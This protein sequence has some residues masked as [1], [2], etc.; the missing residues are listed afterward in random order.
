MA[1]APAY[2]SPM[3]MRPLIE[4]EGY[5][6]DGERL[7]RVVAPMEPRL[8]IRDAV[9]EDCLTLR[10]RVYSSTELWRLRVRP[11]LRRP[12]DAGS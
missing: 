4:Q 5:V 10:W 3:P 2:G 1:S 7:F 6:T 11:V 8:G 12:E 9:L